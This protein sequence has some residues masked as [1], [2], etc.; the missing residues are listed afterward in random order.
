[1]VDCVNEVDCVDELIEAGRKAAAASVLLLKTACLKALGEHPAG[2]HAFLNAASHKW[3]HRV[4]AGIPLCFIV[5][6]TYASLRR[7]LI[8][9]GLVESRGLELIVGTIAV[10]GIARV[11]FAAT[12]EALRLLSANVETSTVG[13]CRPE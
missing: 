4:G 5:D 7:N 13:A 10:V 3:R 11:D 1:M 9:G 6:A 2:W 8:V 12:H